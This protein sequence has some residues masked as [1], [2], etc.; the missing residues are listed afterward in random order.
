MEWEPLEPKAKEG[1]SETTD[2]RSVAESMVNGSQR[3]NEVNLSREAA[4]I[5]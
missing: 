4:T 1:A 3:V 2:G 5:P